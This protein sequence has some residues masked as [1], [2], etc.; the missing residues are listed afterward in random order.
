[1]EGYLPEEGADFCCGTRE[2][3]LK[4]RGMKIEDGRMAKFS[5]SLSGS[6]FWLSLVM[7]LDSKASTVPLTSHK[8]FSSNLH[9]LARICK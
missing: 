7:A 4:T 9:K 1:M 2:A 6:F 5:L 3:K 8:M